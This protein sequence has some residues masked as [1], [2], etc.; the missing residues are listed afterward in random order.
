MTKDREPRA[1]FPLT[2]AQSGM[3]FAQRLDP[4]NPVF[5][6]AQYVEMT[7]P[8]Q[9]AVFATAVAQTIAE[10]ETLSLRFFEDSDGPRQKLDPVARPE[11]GILDLSGDASPE[12]TARQLMQTDSATPTNLAE[13]PIAAFT[14]FILGPEHYYFYARIHHLAIDGYGM[15]LITNRIA[16]RYSA[17]LGEKPTGPAFP[18]YQRVMDEDAAYR[19]SDARLADRQYWRDTITTG[20]TGGMAKGKPVTGHGFH[21]AECALDE[22]TFHALEAASRQAGTNWPDALVALTAAYCRR[23]PQGE[24]LTVGVPNMGRMGSP[25]ARVPAMLVNV[26]PLVFAADEAEPLAKTLKDCAGQLQRARAHGRYRSEQLRRDLGLLGGDRRLYGPLINVLPFNAPPVFNGLQTRLNILGA[27]P[28]D[29]IT[30]T[31]RGGIG[32]NIHLEVDTNPALYSAHDTARHAERLLGFIANAMEA[33][34]LADVPTADAVDHSRFVTEVND[35]AHPVPTTTLVALMAQTVRQQPHAIALVSSGEILTYDELW[36]Q[37]GALAALLQSLGCG[38][39]DIVAIALPRSLHL[40]VGLV[41]ILR[42]GAAY[43]PISDEEP[44]ERLGDILRTARPKCILTLPENAARFGE[45]IQIL[46]PEDWPINGTPKGEAPQ[47]SDPAYVIFTSGS[48]G[49]PKGVVV[50][51]HAIVNRLMWMQQHYGFDTHD[52][53]LQKTPIVFDVSV[54]ELFLALIAGGQLVLAPPGAHRDPKLLA[55]LIR[56]HTITALHFVPSMLATF[57]AAPDAVGLKIQ[58]V[59]CSGEELGADLR[60]RFHTQI[61]AELHNLYGPTEAA[62]D[63]TYWPAGPNDRS[64]PVPIGFPV[65]NTRLYVLDAQLRPQPPGVPGRLFLA[66]RQLANGYLGQP[67]LTAERFIADPFV[68]GERM[69]DTGDLAAWRP[70]GSLGYFGRSDH[71]VKIRGLRIELGE[72][73]AALTGSGLVTQAGVIMREDMPGDRKIIAYIVAAPSYSEAALRKKLSLTL[74]EYML[75]SAI[76][77][78]DALPV[79]INGKLDRKALPAPH[80]SSAGGRA[81]QGPTEILLAEIFANLLNREEISAEDDFFLL[82]GDSLAAVHLMLEIE[83]AFGRELG[84]GTLF[85]QP[86]LE[87]LAALID[88]ADAPFDNGLRPLIRLAEGNKD[89]PP[90]FLVHPAGGLCWCYRHLAAAMDERPVYGLQAPHLNDTDEG[91]ESLETLAATYATRIAEVYPEGPCHIAGWSV[92]G[93]I[94]HAVAIRLQQAGRTVGLLGLLDAYPSECWRA[95]PEPDE[96]TALDSILAIA[97]YDPKDYTHLPD[98]KAVSNFLQQSG[99]PLGQLPTEVLDGIIRVVLSN[100]A[101][102]RGHHHRRFNGPL[103]HIHAASDHQG[104]ALTPAL[105]SGYASGLD[106][107]DLPF[108]HAELASAGA[109][110]PVA[111][112]LVDTMQKFERTRPCAT[113]A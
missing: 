91:P 50:S 79:T 99:S 66:G 89:L 16:E 29:D 37:S 19:A 23:F 2:E 78:L 44:P 95:E 84:L 74:P 47:A 10:A 17:A 25:L 93:I 24:T 68:P 110:Q 60:D 85:E 77:S 4:T 54:W 31:F 11:L 12:A 105:W 39:G 61:T 88:A 87:A 40:M 64:S 9:R 102:V 34:N 81:P 38:S 36:Q 5:N 86:R 97:G 6:T 58:R 70:D 98:R 30:F 107:V 67:E 49:K 72:I 3:W 96:R 27:G 106:I 20:E 41:A 52:R 42:A 33:G 55:A 56:Q 51:H 18:P 113:P 108:M 8:L 14:L 21:R 13:G 62:V 83:Q 59:F 100:N 65:W 109:A 104:T 73:E 71:Q 92:G 69:Y 15:T 90:L 76:I 46:A 28:V 94:A 26:L 32:G 80:F 111:E 45:G 53:I 57:L 43:L 48:T 112:A 22:K 82:G 75:P 35:T 1:T 103:L 63:V 7:G 101:L